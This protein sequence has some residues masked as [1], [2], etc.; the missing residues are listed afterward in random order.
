[1]K[2]LVLF[3]LL[4]LASGAFTAG[5]GLS[6]IV[7]FRGGG[8]I[9]LAV[10]AYAMLGAY[11]FYAL[12]TSGELILPPLPWLP[13]QI[14]FGGPWST[15]PA[16]AVAL[17]VC[18]ALGALFDV[19]VF[20]RLRSSSPLAKLISTLG[21]LLTLQAMM[22]V[23]F[24]PDGQSAPAVLTQRTLTVLG[25]PIPEDQFLFSGVVVVLGA[26][27]VLLYRFSRFGLATR[28]A[29]ESE[30]MAMR[31]GLSPDRLSMLNSTLAAALAGG[32]GI[33]YAPSSTLDSSTLALAV[34][35]ALAAAL[36]ARFNSFTIVTLA[37]FAMGVI[38]SVL[39][40]LQTLSW[41]PT[42]GGNTLPGVSDLVYFLIIAI[43]MYSRGDP[44]PARGTVAERRLPEA[45]A[46]TRIVRP[47]VVLAAVGAVTMI[48]FPAAYREAEINTVIAVVMCLSLVVITGFV[49]QVSLLTFG[50]AGATALVLTKLT[51][52]S[53]IGFPV[54]PLIGIAL[55]VVVGLL[56][57]LPTLRVR[58]VA[59]AIITM[60]G[61]V[62][63]SNFWLGNQS[64]GFN[65]LNGAVGSP[66]LFG[67][68]LGPDAHFGLGPGGTP[69][70]IFGFLCLAVAVGAG[71]LVAALRRGELGQ[72]MLAVRSNERAA[73]AAG[74]NVRETKLVGYGISSLLAGIGGALYAYSFQV[75]GSGNY[76]IT[77]A[78]SF[79]ASAYLGG[80]TSV[81]GA[82]IGG[83]LSTEALIAYLA[84][85]G[86]GLAP[87]TMLVIAGLLLI[88]TVV[89][90]PDGIAG[91]MRRT[92]RMRRGRRGRRTPTSSSSA[93]GLTSPA[94]PPG[95]SASIS[96]AN[97]PTASGRP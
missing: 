46:A 39:V 2:D 53:G 95:A 24:G 54:A 69:S 51:A 44:L 43:V 76:D 15:V 8:V 12:R 91:A 71:M 48:V 70:P 88:L 64:W 85:R 14:H 16:L 35:P 19:I 31:N 11:V 23:R 22:L 74:I 30:A 75:A 13:G 42:A 84:Q 93:T 9:N 4:G 63:I 86:L 61:A 49:G 26:A 66:K 59:L 18:A 89:Q 3:T 92:L 36:L 60:A 41:F 40:W 58:G 33:L 81:S 97:S 50:L 32:L 96:S 67:L 27:L 21:L 17:A 65:P 73:A 82:I 83:L 29:A 10:G 34:I 62:A 94:A 28:A 57:A 38:Q 25:L 56:T 79:V 47:A 72:R 7:S 55:A 20:R 6:A 90:N 80:I 45:P 68:D 37:G 5:L 1:M 78:L 52:S 87:N 77:V